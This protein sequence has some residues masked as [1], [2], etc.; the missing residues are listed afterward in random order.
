MAEISVLFNSIALPVMPEVGL[1]LINTLDD[2]DTPTSRIRDLIGRDPAL[3]AKLLALANSAAFGLKRQVATLDSALSLVGIAKVR[4]LALSACLHNAFSMPA[5][6]DGAGFWRYT[7]R[8][9]G[10][11]QWLA[12]GIDEDK[13]R[14]WL[15]GLMLR[16]GELLIATAHPAAVAALEESPC[17]PGERWE[18]ERAL[19]G[20]DEGEVTAELARRW[21]FP[22]TIQY[23]L[24]LAADPL[25]HKPPV[26]LSGILHLAARL[27]DLPDADAE[28]IDTLPVPVMSALKLKYGWMKADFPDGSGFVGMT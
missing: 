11:A 6:I 27:A 12:D 10:Y 28:A 20:F 13:Q 15:T 18:R 7:Q 21:N 2:D 24:R 26:P 25:S 9:A 5:G 4:A 17:T 3:S 1:A 22:S 23:S 8:C 14:A 19:C 16:L